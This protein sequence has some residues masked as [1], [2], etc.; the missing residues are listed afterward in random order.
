MRKIINFCLKNKF[1]VWLLTLIVAVAGLYSGLHMKME[2]IPNIN[3]PIVSITTS[4]PGAPPDEVAK[5]IT[6]PIEEKVRNLSGV[7]NVM[8]TSFQNAS[9]IQVEYSYKKNMDD[10]EKEIKEIVS[11]LDWPDGVQSPEVSRVD[12]NAFPVMGL[13]VSNDKQSLDALTQTVENDIAPALRAIDGVSTVQV[14]GQQVQEVDIKFD[15]KK[16]QKYGLDKDTV[17]NVIKGAAVNY[18]LGLYQFGNKEKTVVIDGHVTT[19]S[20][21]Q[22]LDIPVTGMTQGQGSSGQAQGAG[23]QGPGMAGGQGSQANPPGGGAN[24]AA[25]GANQPAGLPTVKLKDIASVKLIGKAESISRTNGKRSIGINI[26]KA[27]DANTVDIINKVKD[28][29]KDLEKNYHGLHVVTTLDQGKPIQDSVK[30]MLDKAL[31]GAIFAAVIILLFLRNIRTTLIS[32]VSIPV[33]ILIALLVLHQM[34]ITLNIMT[35]GAMTVAIG[36]VIDD[37]IVVIENIYRRMSLTNE[38]L[39][40]AVLIREATK[41]MLIPIL[42]STLVTIAVFL[43]LGFI[44]GAVGQLFM[45]FALTVVFAL[46]ASFL[47]AITLVPIMTH[48]MFKRGIS[49]KKHRGDEPGKLAGFYKRVLN[50]SLNHKLI[51]FG[52]AVVILVASFFLVP[53]IGVSFLPSDQEKMVVA[54]YNPDPGETEK[55]VQATAK[56][57]E[58]LFL[59]RKGVKVVQYSVGSSNPINPGKS[60][61]ALFFV[62]YDQDFKNFSHEQGQVIKDLQKQ[63]DKGEWGSI[64][65]SASSS[66]NLELYVYG[67]NQEDISGTVDDLMATMKKE[68]GLTDVDSSLS[69][70]YDQYTLVADQSKLSQYGLSAAQ[71]GQ[72]LSS[73]GERPVLTTIKKD[74]KK[75]N[76]YV[77]VDKKNYKDVDDLKDTKIKSPLGKDVNLGDVMNVK[78]GKAPETIARRNGKLYA[79]VTAKV[80]TND[81]GKIST[82]LKKKIDDMKMPSGTSVDFGGVTQQIQESFTQLGLAMLAAIAIVYLILVITFGNALA[83]LAILFSLPFSVIGGFLALW[84]AGEPLSVSALIGALMLIGI[85]VANAIVLI[86]RVSRKER[87]GLST[88]DALLEAGATRLRPI[89]MTAIATIGALLPLAFGFESSG[90]GIISKGLGVAVIGGLASSTLLTLLIVPIVYEFFMKFRKRDFSLEKELAE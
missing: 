2:T 18:P 35:L 4:Y 45:P 36:R 76:V 68:K 12:I 65:M 66:N 3:M 72:T 23:S 52:L 46:L 8:S 47:V 5:D 75:I 6:E 57:A 20:Q 9:S 17:Q 24:M 63:S 49:Q 11:K 70:A 74:G 44:Q 30:T 42:S 58:D 7:E 50:W 89:L 39:K 21:L 82:D 40:G 27:Q 77:E 88:R 85:V 37:S 55:E 73:V 10:A 83:P 16:L 86:E 33:S 13:S 78:S 62:A 69:R 51:T 80:T 41:E 87:E 90:G 67:D 14:A 22:N 28:K 34:N 15:N 60:N 31:F 32:I 71:I 54:T 59:N 61:Q 29:I 38:K 56:K 43:P 64:D 1:A 84:I 81:V 25:G 19:L 53:L 26:V 79:S 48:T